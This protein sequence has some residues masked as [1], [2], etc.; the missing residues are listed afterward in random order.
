M[1]S[2]SRPSSQI[3]KLCTHVN[4]GFIVCGRKMDLCLAIDHGILTLQLL[5]WNRVLRL[6]FWQ[7]L[8]LTLSTRH[9]TSLHF[10]IV[11]YR[12]NQFLQF[13]MLY[14]QI[15]VVY[16]V[17][18]SFLSEIADFS[19]IHRQN[20]QVFSPKSRKIRQ[21]LA[22]FLIIF[23]PYSKKIKFYCIFMHEYF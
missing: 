20:R 11:V 17:S 2:S 1:L 18:R 7:L 15:S 8:N 23:T 9:F 3:Q 22:P 5:E 19:P 12:V 6:T 10:T 13:C 4:F 16:S 14:G 21:F